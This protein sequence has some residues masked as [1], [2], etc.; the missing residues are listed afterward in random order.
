MNYA[1]QDKL[2]KCNNKLYEAGIQGMAEW[3]IKKSKA[4]KIEQIVTPRL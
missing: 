1:K 2:T 4:K 3:G